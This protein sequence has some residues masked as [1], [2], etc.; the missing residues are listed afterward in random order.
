MKTSYL[1]MILIILTGI[2]KPYLLFAQFEFSAEIRPRTE[3]RNGFKTPRSAGQDPAFFTEQRSRLYVDYKEKKYQFRLSIQDVRIWGEEVQIY[4][5]DDGNTFLSEAWGEYFLNS[6]FSLKLGR[7]I[8]TYDN[9]RFFGGLEWAQQG[10]RH[11]ALLVRYN[12]ADKKTRLDLGFAFNSDD[13]RPEPVNLQGFGASYYSIPNEY[14]NF[15]Y[16]WW[17]QNYNQAELSLLALNAGYQNPDSTVSYKQTYGAVM[18]KKMGAFS[19]AGDLYYQSGFLSSK[20]VNAYLAGINLTYQTKLTPL[21]LGVEI[22]SG[23]N[24]D[25]NKPD[26]RHFSPDFGTNHI[27]NGFMDYFFVGPSNAQV[28]VTDLYFKT[29]FKLKRGS[30]LVNVHEFFSGSTQHDPEGNELSK[31]LATETDLVYSVGLTPQVSL[32][33]GYSHLL[34]TQTLRTLRNA[35]SKSNNWVWVMMTFK[36]VLFREEIQPQIN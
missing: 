12:N 11:D 10:R 14:K 35:N 9:Q 29:N 32:D 34:A 23:K 13:D 22:I 6:R 16:G 20:Q 5:Q 21:T 33:V 28:G 18:R 26:I 27:H 31:T 30:L 8:I 19:L 24:S 3:F 7:Q 2:C 15:Q 17:H 4:K 25:D 1:C 36:P